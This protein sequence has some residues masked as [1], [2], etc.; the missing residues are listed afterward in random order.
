MADC[1]D[2]LWKH[3][4]PSWVIDSLCCAT[5]TASH[6]LWQRLPIKARGTFKGF[7]NI[8]SPWKHIGFITRHQVGIKQ[9]LDMA[10]DD[11]ADGRWTASLK[12]GFK[13]ILS[14]HKDNNKNKCQPYRG[15]WHLSVGLKLHCLS[16]AL[17]VGRFYDRVWECAAKTEVNGRISNIFPFRHSIDRMCFQILRKHMCLCCWKG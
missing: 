11:L 17:S 1:T 12:I 6:L 9:L 13:S 10:D 14:I 5:P 8:S 3:A 7:D 4:L 16:G 2:T 15:R